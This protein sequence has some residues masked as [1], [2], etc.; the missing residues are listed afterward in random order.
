MRLRPFFRCWL[1]AEL[2]RTWELPLGVLLVLTVVALQ[3]SACCPA[4]SNAFFVFKPAWLRVPV[5]VPWA[6]LCQCYVARYRCPKGVTTFRTG[7]VLVALPTCGCTKPGPIDVRVSVF[8]FAR[9]STASCRT[10]KWGWGV[11]DWQIAFV[12]NNVVNKPSEGC[13]L[14]DGKV[15]V[16][17]CAKKS[18]HWCFSASCFG[19]ITTAVMVARFL[20]NPAA[21]HAWQLSGM[22]DSDVWCMAD[23]A[24]GC[25]HAAVC[26]GGGAAAGMPE[27][28]HPGAFESTTAAADC[29]VQYAAT[30]STP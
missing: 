13:V 2:N 26:W 10:S 6:G 15:W 16:C 23:G 25:G 20:L 5:A 7:Q 19:T 27:G 9:H 18:Y 28:R 8:V 30:V 29:S 22:L 21:V 24:V 3:V 17:R 4:R 14:A 1:P 12:V 11:Q